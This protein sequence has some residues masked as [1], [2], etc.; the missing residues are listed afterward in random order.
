[1]NKYDKK[2]LLI[3]LAYIL[4]CLFTFLYIALAPP[5]SVMS[6]LVLVCIFLGYFT[7]VYTKK[8]KNKSAV[9]EKRRLS[10]KKRRRRQLLDKNRGKVLAFPTHDKNGNSSPRH[11]N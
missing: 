1:M 5:S 10:A 8:M 4:L 3:L 9:Y 2:K 7:Y 6:V 11:K